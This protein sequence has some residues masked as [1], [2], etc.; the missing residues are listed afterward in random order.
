PWAFDDHPTIRNTYIHAFVGAAFHGMTHAA[1]ANMLSGSHILLK[2]ADANG[3]NYPGLQN[4]ARTLGTVEKRLGVGTDTL[5][6]Y[7]FACDICWKIHHPHT[8][9][10]L[11]S[12]VCDVPDCTGRL[13]SVKRLPGKVAQWQEW[14][15]PLDDPGQREPS[16]LTGFE[17]F[18]DPNKPMHNVTDG[19]GWRAMQAGL[20][21]RRNGTWE[22]RDVDVTEVKQQFVALP[23]GLM[24]QINIDWF[25]AVKDGCHSTGALYMTLCNNPRSI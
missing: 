20:E 14:R 1:V 3:T 19:W 10:T 13:F 15:G 4:F 12:S 6:T 23:N 22:I 17:A 2:S 5:I 9:S 7:F 25:Q 11:P 18:D 24:V 21:R 8:L 16:R